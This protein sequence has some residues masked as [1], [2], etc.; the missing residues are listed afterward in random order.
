M[1]RKSDLQKSLESSLSSA[2]PV[3]IS[4]NS[5]D[6]SHSHAVVPKIALDSA[7]DELCHMRKMYAKLLAELAKTKGMN[8]RSSGGQHDS[9]Q[10]LEEVRETS[11]ALVSEA[12]SAIANLKAR[13]DRLEHE[14]QVNF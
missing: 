6:S 2:S 7:H 4:S 12:R 9:D 3:N 11:M 5:D 13:Q 10:G 14:V 1:I 8:T